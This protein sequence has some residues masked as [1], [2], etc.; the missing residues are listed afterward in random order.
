[1]TTPRGKGPFVGRRSPSSTR[2]RGRT[3]TSAAVVLVDNGS[4]RAASSLTLRAAATALSLALGG[5][6]VLP[7]SIAF[8]DGVPAADL[9]GQPAHTLRQALGGLVE[10]GEHSAIVTPLFLGPSGAIRRGLNA[11]ADDLDDSFQLSVGACLV[12]ENQPADERVARAL[13]AQVLHAARRVGARPPLKVLLVDHGTPSRP[14]NAVRSRLTCELRRLLGARASAVGE[15]SMERRDGSEYDFND[16][17]LERALRAPPFDQGDV[18]LAMAFLLPGRHAGDGGDVAQIVQGAQADSAASA[19]L[20]VHTTPPL[21]TH[22][23]VVDVL[24]DRVRA[25]DAALAASG[26]ATAGG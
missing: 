8:S 13:A 11:C 3:T 20:R 6:E 24:A 10:R 5:R 2:M 21:A 12:D 16:P 7:A 26:G 4:R 25:S 22:P 9:G 19:P 23:L 18:I 15:A 17:L 1:M 14:V